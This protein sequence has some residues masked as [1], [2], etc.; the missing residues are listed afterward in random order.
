MNR[1]IEGNRPRPPGSGDVGDRSRK[2]S[3]ITYA[4]CCVARPVARSSGSAA[5]AAPLHQGPCVP[6]IVE[7]SDSLF[8]THGTFQIACCYVHDFSWRFPAGVSA[9]SLARKA[10]IKGK[11]IGMVKEILYTT[12]LDAQGNLIH[13]DN[14]IK[15]EKY[16]CPI[17]KND[18]IIRK[19][20]KTGKGSRRPHFAHN[21][22]SPNCKPETV[23]HF[24]F[25]KMLINL[26]R[27][28]TKKNSP[29]I[30]NWSCDYCGGLN[31]GNLLE[32]IFSIKEEY[33]LNTCKP[34]IALL[35][36]KGTV[37]TVIEIVVTHYPEELVLKY[38][39]ENNIIC[40]QLLL[41]SEEDLKNII[42]IT[43]TPTHVDYCLNPKCSNYLKELSSRRI[44]L[45]R[46]QCNK[47]FAPREV[48]VI[49]ANGVF[50]KTESS[51]FT[52]E[53]LAYIK[54]NK[55]NIT[56]QIDKKTK[57]KKPVSSCMN[58]KRIASRYIKNRMFR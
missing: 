41:S 23:L 51:V 35:N 20:G 49:E 15:S 33:N 8:W 54:A 38:Y 18:F 3:D 21:Q 53:E 39:K 28:Y 25:K 5:L 55:S 40:I 9:P 29:L 1:R 19:S 36:N 37:V 4:I 44:L 58:C 22:L 46:I 31:N 50:G 52:D 30:I 32:A 34:D 7:Y 27:E 2:I 57:E 17:C 56:I 45:K 12:A 43:K 47:C 48:F 6:R 13:I 26:L 10:K 16:Y 11:L 14:A 24:S 42:N